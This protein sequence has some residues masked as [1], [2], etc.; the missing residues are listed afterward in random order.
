MREGD[1]IGCREERVTVRGFGVDDEGCIGKASSLL[2]AF[3]SGAVCAIAGLPEAAFSALSVEREAPAWRSIS[4]TSNSCSFHTRRRLQTHDPNRKVQ[5]THGPNGLWREWSR[6]CI[7]GCGDF[8]REAIEGCC[9]LG[10][11]S[12]RYEGK[13]EEVRQWWF[14]W[15]GGEGAS[16]V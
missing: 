1:C 11:G 5:R 4:I 9:E 13:A 14:R 16:G 12:G 8:C 6:I 15:L 2:S 3:S 7:A 10:T